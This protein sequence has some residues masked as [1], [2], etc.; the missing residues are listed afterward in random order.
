M[1]RPLQRILI[2]AFLVHSATFNPSP[3]QTQA[4]GLYSESDFQL[5]AVFTQTNEE[6]CTIPQSSVK[7]EVAHVCKQQI[8]LV[9]L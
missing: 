6:K 5:D 8:K 1:S 9:F 4:C 7:D 3:L 2:S